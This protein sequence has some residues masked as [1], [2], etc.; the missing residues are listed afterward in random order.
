ML[1]SAPLPISLPTIAIRVGG[2]THDFGGW[3]LARANKAAGQIAAERLRLADGD[4]LAAGARRPGSEQGHPC[5]S[6]AGS[7]FARSSMSLIVPALR[8][9]NSLVD[10]N[11]GFADEIRALS[12]WLSPA[13]RTAAPSLPAPSMFRISARRSAASDCLQLQE[14]SEQADDVA[15]ARACDGEIRPFPALGI[16]AE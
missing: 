10:R 16:D 4:A 7:V 11:C 6:L 14:V 15:A 8:P 5:C 9:R 12:V 3:K 1:P 2:L 13:A